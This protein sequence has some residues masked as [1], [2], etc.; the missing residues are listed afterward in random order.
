MTQEISNYLAHVLKVWTQILGGNETLMNSLDSDT[1]DLLQLHAPGISSHD[2]SIVSVLM[3]HGKI[4]PSI[5]SQDDRNIV[6]NNLESISCLIPSLSTLFEDLKYLTAPVKILRQLCPTS[7]LSTREAMWRLFTGRYLPENQWPLQTWEGGADY[8]WINGSSSDQFEFGYQQ[9]ML[10]IWRH[11]PELCP[12][13]PRKEDG[14]ETPIPQTPDPRVRY[15]LASLAEKVGFESDQISQLLSSD[16]DRKLARQI[17]LKARSPEYFTYKESAFNGYVTEISRIFKL[18]KDIQPQA[19]SPCFVVAGSGEKMQRRSGRVFNKAYHSDRK[20]LFLSNFYNPEKRNM[21]GISSFAVRVS[22]F[23]AFFGRQRL[24]NETFVGNIEK[25]NFSSPDHLTGAIGK[26]LRNGR[27]LEKLRRQENDS[28]LSAEPTNLV[29]GAANVGAAD[30]VVPDPVANLAVTNL[31]V[32][33]PTIPDPAVLDPVVPE[34]DLPDPV[35][36]ETVKGPLNLP[37]DDIVD[38]EMAVS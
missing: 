24:I 13:C 10:Y 20:L 31:A 12:E 1:I 37:S 8:K 22:V 34:P 11:W 21:G 26:D 2:F 38:V 33:D 29:A 27:S 25:H 36:H 7:R 14:E 15:G 35:L 6:R 28:I 30:P 3:E 18:A 5:L 32:P 23:F 4:F 19:L 17:L 9:V 16:P